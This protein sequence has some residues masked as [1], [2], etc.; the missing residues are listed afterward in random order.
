MGELPS[1]GWATAQKLKEAGIETV[2]DVQV[3][4]S[5][6]WSL[7]E[8]AGL[9]LSSDIQMSWAGGCG[10]WTEWAKLG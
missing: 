3:G 6:S 10:I 2:S 8:D 1:V 4:W 7:R 5:G 9:R